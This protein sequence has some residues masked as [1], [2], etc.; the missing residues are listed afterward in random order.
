M[1]SHCG[2]YINTANVH[3]FNYTK[4]F[5]ALLHILLASQLASQ[6]FE[7]FSSVDRISESRGV[8]WQYTLKFED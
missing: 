1:C 2:F 7:L 3:I 8:N 6:N 5:T 4:H